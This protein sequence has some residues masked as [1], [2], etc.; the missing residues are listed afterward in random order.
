MGQ[1]IREGGVKRGFSV[2][3]CERGVKE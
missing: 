2:A 1:G 3:A